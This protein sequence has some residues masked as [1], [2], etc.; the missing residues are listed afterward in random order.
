MFGMERNLNEIAM[1]VAAGRYQKTEG[2]PPTA[3]ELIADATE[4]A[5]FLKA[6]EPKSSDLDVFGT[7]ET[8]NV[9]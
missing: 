9:H 1:F 3:A 5:T 7:R 8:A 4:I 2:T 6:G